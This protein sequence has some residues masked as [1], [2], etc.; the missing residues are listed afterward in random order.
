MVFES[1]DWEHPGAKNFSAPTFYTFASNNLTYEC[2]YN[3]PTNRTI[4][5]GNNVTTDEMCMAIG[6]F[7]P[8]VALKACYNNFLVN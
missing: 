5:Y 7:F 3:N 1:T 8:A 4:R 2:T 6:Y